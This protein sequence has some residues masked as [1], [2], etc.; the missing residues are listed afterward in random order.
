MTIYTFQ[1]LSFFKNLEILAFDFLLISFNL[2]AQLITNEW[3]F[4]AL[5]DNNR[6]TST[7]LQDN[8]LKEQNRVSLVW[9]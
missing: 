8:R 2:H 3:S 6:M 5:Q 4:V 7:V 1:L 9:I